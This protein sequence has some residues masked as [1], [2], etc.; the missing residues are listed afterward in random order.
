M[1]ENE[2][3]CEVKNAEKICLLPSQKY[4]LTVEEAAAYFEIGEKKI[5]KLAAE[6]EDDGIFTKH[7]VKLLIIR[8]A[9]ENYIST[10]PQI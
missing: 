7:G 8:P 10:T 6:H 5:R 3:L 9:F 2:K 4:C 1:K